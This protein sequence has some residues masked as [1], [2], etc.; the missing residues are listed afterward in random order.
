MIHILGAEFDKFEMRE[1]GELSRERD[2]AK[3]HMDVIPS[4]QLGL[5]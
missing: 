4:F 1:N 2:G 3:K 5:V